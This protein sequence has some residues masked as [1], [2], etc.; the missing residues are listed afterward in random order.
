VKVG[1]DA[2]TDATGIATGVLLRSINKAG[3]IWG[4]GFSPKVIWGVVKQKGFY[5]MRVD[6]SHLGR[7][8]EVTWPSEE[9]LSARDETLCP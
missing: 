5:T 3:R 8:R 6:R 4:A 9:I 2:W 1:I 7:D